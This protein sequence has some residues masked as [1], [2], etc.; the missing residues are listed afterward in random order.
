ME[1]NFCL[2]GGQEHRN[3]KL[4]Q[5]VKCTSPSL[6]YLYLEFIKKNNP[7]G[8]A[9]FKQEAN[10]VPI[11]QIQ[12]QV[13]SATF[14]FW[15]Y[16][17]VSFLQML[18]RKII[19]MPDHCLTSLVTLISLGFHLYQWGKICWLVATMLKN[20]CSEA[21]IDGRKPNHSLRATGLRNCFKLAYYQ[22]K[23]IK[24]RTGHHSLEALRTYERTTT[25]QHQAIS[26]IL[27]AE[28]KITFQQA[29][30]SK[31]SIWQQHSIPSTYGTMSNL[32]QL[33]F[34]F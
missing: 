15:T 17:S 28:K 31:Q 4:S 25:E 14:I 30:H 22:K 34:Q 23:I 21:Q 33:H 19:S 29:L 27:S 11:N 10:R 8:L 5:L 1:K 32:P 20:M 12:K 13:T 6:H 16:I 24:E 26:D 7:G 9:H 2:R 3:L 18:G